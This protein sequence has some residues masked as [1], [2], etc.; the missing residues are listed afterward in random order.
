MFL[1]YNK[2]ANRIFSYGLNDEAEVLSWK[3]SQ[4][5]K[6]PKAA[7]RKHVAVL[8]ENGVVR[9]KVSMHGRGAMRGRA[10][11]SEP[12]GANG[13]G[14][15]HRDGAGTG[16][17]GLCAPRRH[18]EARSR[19]PLDLGVPGRHQETDRCGSLVPIE[20]V[21]CGSRS[22]ARKKTPKGPS[23]R[24]FTSH[25]HEHATQLH[26]TARRWF[27]SCIALH[28]AND[29]ARNAPHGSLH[30]VVFFF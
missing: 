27:P 15:Q 21:V 19:R 7:L 13:I 24:L 26:D 18:C 22:L 25:P 2:S 14:R 4:L 8:Q 10:S 30:P 1:R 3:P 6:S 20:I 9:K 12:A 28:S 16:T 5:K 11:G 17:G 29:G 23:F